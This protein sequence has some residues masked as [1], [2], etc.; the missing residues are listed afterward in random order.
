[1]GASNIRLVVI[2]IT[3]LL[4]ASRLN[5]LELV[6]RSIRDYYILVRDGFKS[7][8]TVSTSIIP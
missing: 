2:L 5:V 6:G 3:W 8:I 7:I 4:G 1:M